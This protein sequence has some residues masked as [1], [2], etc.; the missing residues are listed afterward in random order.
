[1][2]GS[3]FEDCHKRGY[4]IFDSLFETLTLDFQGDV[5]ISSVA[6]AIDRCRS[7]A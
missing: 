2:I 5:M 7:G 4:G 6:T 3:G 1:M